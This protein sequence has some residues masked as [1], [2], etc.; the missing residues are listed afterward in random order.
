MPPELA[1]GV[2]PS[3]HLYLETV[4]RPS[5]RLAPTVVAAIR[6]AFER[7]VG[8]GL[9]H[10]AAAE[11]ADNLANTLPP[12][13]AFG[14]ELGYIFMTRL[15]ASADLANAWTTLELPLPRAELTNLLA[16][17]PLMNGAEYINQDCLELW[18]NE[19][20]L[21]VQG[22]IAAADGDALQ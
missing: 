10:L 9:L 13:L 8:S 22:E 3:G 12:S 6:E 2:T 4:P 15:C 21:A 20:Q 18:W 5:G 7:G 1:L 19:L 14:R 17:A 11:L 16:G